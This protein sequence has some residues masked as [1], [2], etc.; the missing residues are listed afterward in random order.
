MDEQYSPGKKRSR[1]PYLHTVS[2]FPGGNKGPVMNWAEKEVL[3]PSSPLLPFSASKWKIYSSFS[4]KSFVVEQV[5]SSDV[6]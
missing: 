2:K 5:I 1:C 6:D 3:E 4:I